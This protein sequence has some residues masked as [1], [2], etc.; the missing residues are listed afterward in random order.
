MRLSGRFAWIA[1]VAIP[2]FL[3]GVV[4]DT[5]AVGRTLPSPPPHPVT[6]S[7]LPSLLLATP[8]GVTAREWSGAIVLGIA[9]SSSRQDRAAGL[10]E[11]LVAMSILMAVLFALLGVVD[12]NSSTTRSNREYQ[13]TNRLAQ[14]MLD[15]YGAYTTKEL[16]ELFMAHQGL[17]IASPEYNSS[18]TGVLKNTIDWVSRP[19]SKEEGSLACYDG[20]VA[21]LMSASPGGLGGLRGLVTVRSIL[22]SIRVLVLPDQVAVG[23]AH[24]AFDEQGNLTGSGQRESVEALGAKLARTVTA[25]V[26]I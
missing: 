25:L 14:N 17:L 8:E 1:C 6:V 3:S 20:K 21:A 19:A 15:R 13:L 4:A 26:A 7:D 12:L 16:M 24:Q 10:I 22:S 23:T 2:C 11:L 9:S 5:T 18:I